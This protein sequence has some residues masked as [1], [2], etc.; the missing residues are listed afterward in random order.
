M[1]QNRP[2]ESTL[3]DIVYS[4]DI[5][6]GRMI[7]RVALYLL[8][9]IILM[10]LYTATQFKGLKSAEAMDLAQVGR[11]ISLQGGI[12]TKCVRPLTI[13]KM[14][15]V[16]PDGNPHIFDHPDVLHAPAY[17]VVL[18]LGYKFYEMLGINLWKIEKLSGSVMPAEQWVVIPLNH[19]FAVLTGIIVYLMGKRLFAREIGFLGMTIYYLSNLVWADSISGLGITMAGF[20]SAAAFYCIMLAMLNRRDRD[21]LAA[22]LVP[23]VLSILFATTAFYTRYI[24]A[25]IVPGMALYA[26]LMAGRFRGGTRFA[27]AIILAFTVL[28]FPWLYRN[29]KICKNPFGMAAHTVMLETSKYP[30]NALERCSN[31]DFSPSV[32]WRNMKDKWIKN[33]TGCFANKLPSMGGGVLPSIF[34]VTFLYHF[35]RPQVNYLRWG[36]GLSILLLLII[37]GFFGETTIRMLHV[38]WPFVILY[39]LAFYVILIERLDLGVR[40]YNQILRG[41]FVAVATV[42]IVL[43]LM[44]PHESRPYPPYYAP[45][46]QQVTEWL[47]PTEVMC[48]DM[49]WA[50][51]WYGNRVSILLPQT[52]D[53]F[54]EINDYEHYI[55][56]LYITT[57]TKNKPFVRSLLDGPD[58]SWL[59]I[60]SGHYPPDFPL[61]KGVALNRQDQ[62]FISDRQ[63]WQISIEQ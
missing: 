14:K 25:V 23:F 38:F 40:L 10:L 3:H 29:Y 2:F 27:V 24:T 50:T 7:I 39:A 11:N 17:P 26:W 37:A 31:P 43:T 52:L 63:R 22:W 20:F 54:Y 13:W 32:V 47:N 21:S 4:I 49:P 35:V 41:A 16:S 61:K 33:Y 28:I 5:G 44:P 18:A 56:G 42:P 45:I 55:S 1:A 36:V 62:I 34:L 58:K 8:F 59:P 51:A 53:D 15:Q 6:T 60:M 30:E 19:L 48:T 57:L 12:Q 9:I 46:I